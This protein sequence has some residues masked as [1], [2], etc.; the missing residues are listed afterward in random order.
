MNS[1]TEANPLGGWTHPGSRGDDLVLSV[2]FPRQQFDASC[3][4]VRGTGWRLSER[5]S[6]PGHA[7]TV[8]LPAPPEFPPLEVHL[9]LFCSLALAVGSSIS[10]SHKLALCMLPGKCDPTSKK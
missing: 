5:A 10:L 7:L 9:P 3:A 4:C 2:C 8:P 6:L 1:H